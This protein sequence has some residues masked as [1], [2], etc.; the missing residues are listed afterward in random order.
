MHFEFDLRHHVDFFVKLMN[1]ESTI[2]HVM[3]NQ[4]MKLTSIIFTKK[5]KGKNVGSNEIKNFCLARL[6]FFCKT[7]VKSTH[8]TLELI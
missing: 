5:F 1:Y 4:N 2:L 3:V 8:V 7:F 6:S